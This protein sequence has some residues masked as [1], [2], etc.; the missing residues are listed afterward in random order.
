[1]KKLIAMLLAL[2]MVCS[3]AACGSSSD[4]ASDSA[5]TSATTSEAPA[6]TEAGDATEAEATTVSD[7]EPVYG[8]TF[9]TYWSEFTNVYDVSAIDQANFITLYTDTLWGL[10][11]ADRE[12][13]GFKVA[14]LDI[15]Y[16]SGEI[17]ESWEIADDYSSMSVKIHD[18]I[19]FA[20]KTAVGVDAQYDIY[21]GR[22]LTAADVKYSYDRVL[23]LDGVEL[24]KMEMT[25]WQT[26]LSMI[27]SIEVVDDYNLI[28]HFNT[29]TEL[30]V[31]NFM[32][33]MLGICGP[34]WD[35]LTQEQQLDWHYGGS[36]GPFILTDYVNDNTMTFVA[37]PNYWNVDEDGNALPYLGTL[38]LVHMT[39]SATMLSS[40]IAG[41]LDALVANNALIDTDEASQIVSMDG[42]VTYSYSSDAPAV[43][44]KQGDNPVEA[45]TD[46]NVRMAM[47][48]AIDLDAISTFMGYSYDSV[49]DMQIP[50]FSSGSSLGNLSALS[51][52]VIDSYTTYDPDLAKQM[53]TDAG[54]GDGF[55]FDVYIYQAQ[56]VQA[57]Q[58]AAEYLASVG[59]TMNITVCQTP[60]DMSIHGNDRTD[61]ACQYGSV[62]TD[63]PSFIT[64]G[65]PSD[66]MMNTIWQPAED[67][68]ALVEDFNNATTLDEQIAA[69][70]AL[71]EAYLAAHYN[72]I[73]AHG[74]QFNTYV[75]GRVG[76]YNGELWTNYYFA[77]DIMARIWVTD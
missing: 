51:Q 16:I 68:D 27:D 12:E 52:D 33:K 29:N 7:G 45:L 74:Q 71:D 26:D 67:F 2:A 61:P 62:G 34:E 11:W 77:S 15:N 44:L 56:P 35:E 9:T 10:D 23:G 28:F 54:Y 72:L 4:S 70:D 66:G 63:K 53:L 17:A 48:Y 38:K 65:I 39:D 8:G 55:E 41:N 75:N 40:F 42:V 37:N 30:A 14:Y 57:F 73:V 18:N 58:L 5:D 32:C 43:A 59:I 6:T 31:Q 24:V 50:F 19:Y 36:T 20:D 25:D 1:M 49:E 76:G 64:Y 47:Q 13:L 22:Q 3:L 46:L 21:G 69:A 60:S